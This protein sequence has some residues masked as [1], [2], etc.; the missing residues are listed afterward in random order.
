MISEIRFHSACLADLRTTA[1]WYDQR[2]SWL[3]DEMH[4]E[5]RQHLS[6]MRSYPHAARSLE[7]GFRQLPLKKFPFVIVVELLEDL[8]EVRAVFHT[9]RDPNNK[10]TPD[11]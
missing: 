6:Y 9:S 8:L 2:G 1:E 3:V 5:L 11:E 10:L 7:A 4:R